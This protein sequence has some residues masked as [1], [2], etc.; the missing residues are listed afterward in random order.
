MCLRLTRMYVPVHT[1]MLSAC[2]TCVVRQVALQQAVDTLSANQVS[3][4]SEKIV[5]T[6]SLTALTAN[7]NKLMLEKV[8]Y[9]S[10]SFSSVELCSFH[11]CLVAAMLY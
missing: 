7:V 2:C 4:S 5:L 1:S 10:R 11:T 9:A 6:S 8:C 3:H